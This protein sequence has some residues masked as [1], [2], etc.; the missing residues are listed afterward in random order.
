M[1]RLIVPGAGT[2]SKAEMQKKRAE[3]EAELA[4]VKE[5]VK[6]RRKAKMVE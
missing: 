1:P 6:K 4:E 2:M 3:M 5:E